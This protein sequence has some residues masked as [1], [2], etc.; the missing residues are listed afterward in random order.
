MKRPVVGVIGSA[1][2]AEN[3][4]PAQRV[5]ER[6]LTAVADVVGALPL[7][8]AGDPDLT[9][10]DACSKRSMACC[11]PALAPMCIRRTSASK[12]I[13]LRALRQAP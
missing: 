5:G 12:S 10:I 7:I 1:H 9:D 13:Q 6:N 3:R 11:S 8:F 2:L 4:F